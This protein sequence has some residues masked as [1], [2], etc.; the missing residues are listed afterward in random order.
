MQ[1]AVDATSKGCDSMKR[2]R[3]HKND[4]RRH[5]NNEQACS[6]RDNRT[7]NYRQGQ[8]IWNTDK[9]GR[10]AFRDGKRQKNDKKVIYG[11]FHIINI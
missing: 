6:R 5:E 1:V 7:K 11:L 9:N 2:N 8:Q 3:P 4:N 10:K